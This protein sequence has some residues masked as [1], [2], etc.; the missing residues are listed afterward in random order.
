MQ[1]GLSGESNS[2][3]LVPE[4]RIIPLDHRA[5]QHSSKKLDMKDSFISRFGI[6]NEY[7]PTALP[8]FTLDS[9]HFL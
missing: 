1:K 3:P 8:F 6:V 7:Y 5:S 2:G 4:T 9:F